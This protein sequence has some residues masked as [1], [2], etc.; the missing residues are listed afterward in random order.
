MDPLGII[1]SALAAGA[2]AAAKDTASQ[3]MKDAYGGLKALVQRRFAG[4]QSA[5]VA[6][7]EHEKK[8]DVWQ[9]PLKD[10]LLESG[11]DKDAAIVQ[12]ARQLLTLVQ[13]QQASMGKYNVQIGQATGVAIGDHPQVTIG[14]TPD[15]GS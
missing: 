3:A 4:K 12:A 2:A 13:P 10:A 11:A 6:L 8:P 9:A 1:V 15:E 14:D 7:T 5:E